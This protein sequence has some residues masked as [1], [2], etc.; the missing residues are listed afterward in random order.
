MRRSRTRRVIFLAGSLFLALAAALVPI[1]LFWTSGKEISI[2]GES[3][4]MPGGSPAH[5]AYL[6]AGPRGILHERWNT[7]LEGTPSGPPA[8]AGGTAYVA[9]S[10]GL[11]YALELETG[12]PLWRC[13]AGAG[14]TSMPAVFEAGILV[15]TANGRVINVDSQGGLAWEFEAGGAV[16]SAPIP[17][18]G[19]V[20]F[21]SDDGCLYCLDA[22]NGSRLWSYEAGSQV[23]VSPCLYEGQ[24]FGASYEGDLFALDAGSG[25]LAWTYRSQGLP[26]VHPAADDGRVFL[27]TELVVS[28]LDA[29]SGKRL[30]E[31]NVGPRIISNLVLRGNKLM[32]ARGEEGATMESLSL[33]ARTGD[34]LWARSCGEAPRWTGAAATNT[35]LYLAGPE[36]ILAMEVESG[37]SSLEYKMR[38]AL[39]ET[40]ALTER[41]MLVATDAH[42]VYCLEE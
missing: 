15:G 12:K 32:V 26:V 36:S 14:I 2:E 20:Y 31:V 9:C 4:T 5:A 42:K 13:D 33:D 24:V 39:A 25:R 29:Q 38:G 35:E 37:M 34:S 18:G 8:V 17:A 10:N 22:S 40:L 28:C 11:L 16:A 21:G 3:W 23:R 30:W 1:V 41:F 6:P 27:A 7:R 19:R